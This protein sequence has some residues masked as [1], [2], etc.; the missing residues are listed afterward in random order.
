MKKLLLTL[1][2][3]AA[4]LYAQEST[5]ERIKKLCYEEYD[6]EKVIQLSNELINNTELDDSTRIDLFFMRGISLYALGNENLA[7]VN[8]E[9]ILKIRKTYTPDVR[10]VS[11][12]I[13]L[14]FN[15]V[16]AEFIRQNP[17]QATTPEDIAKII[18]L[19]AERESKIKNA[20]VK[21]IFIP[22]WGHFSKG[23]ATKGMILGGLSTANLAAMVYFIFD[24]NN[25]QA[26]YLKE[27]NKLFVESKYSSYN[28]AYKVRNSLI[29]SYA[30]LWVYSQI[31]LHFFSNSLPE[32]QLNE[33]MNNQIK[34]N[35]V[36]ISISIPMN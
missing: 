3:F 31:D 8:F 10:K 29:L 25:K 30:A 14:I 7:R 24:T 1:F 13:L 12:K 21:N 33:T 16:K 26:V 36:S 27:T 2:L 17:M 6:Y 19:A 23:S 9:N 28:S 35:T 34:E 11:P 22:G 5:I 32:A 4:V 18:S 20:A 15:E